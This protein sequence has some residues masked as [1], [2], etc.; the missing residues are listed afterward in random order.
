MI[1]V[2]PSSLGAVHVTWADS[3]APLA[4]T[5][6]GSAG[7]VVLSGDTALEWTD[8][9]P[10]ALLLT[11]RTVNVYWVPDVRPLTVAVV[12]GGVPVIVVAVCAVEPTYG[13]TTYLATD[14]PLVGA[15][16]VTVADAFPAVAPTPVAAPGGGSGRNVASTQ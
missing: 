14:P 8:S 13:V 5:L 12:A 16:Q 7:A 9:G 1:D 3:V 11:A 6:I 15:D 4:L 2:P 10:G